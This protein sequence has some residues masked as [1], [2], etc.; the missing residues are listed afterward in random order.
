MIQKKTV[1]VR[2]KFNHCE[3]VLSFASVIVYYVFICAYVC[4]VNVCLCIHLCVYCKSL[5]SVCLQAFVF[6]SIRTHTA[7]VCMFVYTNLYVCVCLC[8]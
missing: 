3:N 1:F 7:Y 5:V 2:Q 8:V 6:I 4:S